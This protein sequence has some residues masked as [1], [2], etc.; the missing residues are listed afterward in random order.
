M[1]VKIFP[2]ILLST[3]LMPVASATARPAKVEIGGKELSLRW[4][5]SKEGWSL[6]SV[7]AFGLKGNPPGR[8]TP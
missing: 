2:A 5:R 6:V 1:N 4:Q 3:L 7:D 8:N